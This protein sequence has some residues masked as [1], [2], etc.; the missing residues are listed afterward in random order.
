VLNRVPED[1]LT[2]N[3]RGYAFYQVKQLGEAVADYNRP[4]ELDPAFLPARS[5]RALVLVAFAR[6]PQALVDIDWAVAEGETANST[7]YNLQGD[8]LLQLNRPV[9]AIQAFDKALRLNAGYTD[10]ATEQQRAGYSS[11]K[12]PWD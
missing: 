2:L 10:Y 6:Y 3:N 5:S 9:P 11:L 7:L 1:V 8:C 4:L 12:N